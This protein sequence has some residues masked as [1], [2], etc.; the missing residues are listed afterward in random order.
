V[1]LGPLIIGNAGCVR[2]GGVTAP[3]VAHDV[4]LLVVVDH[5]GSLATQGPEKNSLKKC[6]SYSVHHSGPQRGVDRGLGT[7]AT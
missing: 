1:A 5:S 3:D 2:G 6:L 4:L 7:C